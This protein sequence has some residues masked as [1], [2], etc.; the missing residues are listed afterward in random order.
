M[1]KNRTPKRRADGGPVPRDGGR[2]GD[3][4]L[5]GSKEAGS[6]LSLAAAGARD[7]PGL[8][9]PGA[10]F[11][12][13][14]YPFHGPQEGVDVTNALVD[15]IAMILWKLQGGNDPVNRLEAGMLLERAFADGRGKDA[16]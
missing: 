7:C 16:R 6:R 11:R 12:V 10:P 14:I 8:G 3:E 1:T 13:I 5:A 2:A 15:T 4:Q 9:A